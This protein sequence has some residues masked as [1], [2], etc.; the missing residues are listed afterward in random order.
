MSATASRAAAPLRHAATP[1]ARVLQRPLHPLATPI[2]LA[3]DAS[4]CPHGG[5]LRRITLP[6][7]VAHVQADSSA[8]ITVMPSTA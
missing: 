3:C 5:C 6:H 7:A 8:A 4:V 1:R 2:P